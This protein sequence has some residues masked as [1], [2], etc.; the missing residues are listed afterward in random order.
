[1]GSS[2]SRGEVDA[3]IHVA[4]AV[5]RADDAVAPNT[6]DVACAHFDIGLV[7]E[8][9]LPSIHESHVQ[10]AKMNDH[11]RP[12]MLRGHWTLDRAA[13]NFGST[14]RRRLAWPEQLESSPA[15]T[16]AR[17]RKIQDLEA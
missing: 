11:A 15:R 8:L 13:I 9:P 14:L 4:E 5:G 17:G 2:L 6:K 16:T 7:R 10:V 3:A 12:S 1:M